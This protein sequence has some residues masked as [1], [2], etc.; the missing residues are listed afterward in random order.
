MISK[1]AITMKIRLKYVNT[2]LVIIS[3]VVLEGE[4][5]GALLQPFSIR[6]FTCAWVRPVSAAVS[7][8]ATGFLRIFAS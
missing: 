7:I 8:R 2:L 6:S 1:T 3:F 5:T 4:S